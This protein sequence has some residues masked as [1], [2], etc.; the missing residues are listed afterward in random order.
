MRAAARRDFPGG[1]TASEYLA[2]P[3]EEAEVAQDLEHLVRAHDRVRH[4]QELAAIAAAA[5]GASRESVRKMRHV[6][7]HP[8]LEAAA[9]SGAASLDEC[10]REACQRDGRPVPGRRTTVPIDDPVAAV[11]LLLRHFSGEELLEALTQVLGYGGG[12]R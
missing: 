4:E 1:L 12:T 9:C 11:G 5:F 2:I 10:Y 3:R 7:R 6:A 8:D